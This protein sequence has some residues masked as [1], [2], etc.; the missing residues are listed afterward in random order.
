M[1]AV[2]R[3]KPTQEYRNLS[4]QVL[5]SMGWLSATVHLPSQQSLVGFL[6]QGG[7]LLCLTG[8]TVPDRRQPLDFLALRKRHVILV[9]PTTESELG[10]ESDASV[11]HH[12][13]CLLESGQVTGLLRGPS[14]TRLS[15][16]LREHKGFL[17][18]REAEL[19]NDGTSRKISW[20]A[21]NDQALLA[22][23]E[24]LEDGWSAGGH[25]PA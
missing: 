5:S 16:Y 24:W 15:D 9:A 14:R 21:V 2:K 10:N 18:L 6:D 19:L 12:V 25:P 20:V 22:I 11:D 7:R 1:E 3:T 8:V 17:L 23:T 13:T 4:V